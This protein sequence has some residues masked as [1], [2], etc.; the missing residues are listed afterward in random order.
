MDT[1]SPRP[2]K[3]TQQAGSQI[4]R[5]VRWLMPIGFGGL[6]VLFIIA[7]LYATAVLRQAGEADERITS[8][9][10]RRNEGLEAMRSALLTSTTALRDYLVDP[11]DEEARDH[12]R[13][14]EEQWEKATSDLARY[15]RMAS[16]ETHPLLDQLKAKWEEY[17][18]IAAASL[19]WPP[20]RRRSSGYGLLANELSPRREQFLRELD[21]IW[22][23][24][25]LRLRGSVQENSA[26][27]RGLR[28]RLAIILVL[29]GLMGVILAG[30]TMKYLLR[31]EGTAQR[32]LEQS[33]ADRDELEKL[34][35]RLVEI[36]E[37]E[38]KSIARELHDEVGQSLSA[39]LVDVGNAK[40]AAGGDAEMCATL[41]SIQTLA[42]R[43][44]ASARNLSL[45][46]RPSMLD[47]LGLI[48]ALKWE[49]RETARRTGMSVV[50]TADDEE[51]DLPEAQRTAIYRVVQEALHNAARHSGAKRVEVLVRHHGGHVV[52]VVHD[53]GRGFDPVSTRGMGLLGMQERVTQLGGTLTIQSAPGDGAVLRIDLE[54]PVRR[55]KVGA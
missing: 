4:L 22:R 20:E 14:A 11:D 48:P 53:D 47:D 2:M 21:E 35:A 5:G 13:R 27:I 38:R 31:L 34:S 18:E 44:L 24:D 8:E 12:R 1:Y 6:F 45:L 9:F 23:T 7:S 42:E 32:Q 28:Q 17:W 15:R 37:E 50:M 49:A 51:L 19:Q 16:S 46:L 25:E 39:L 36:Q 40:N 43:T 30:L 41:G 52:C 26:L 3:L 29:C 33:I 54:A 10:I 55:E